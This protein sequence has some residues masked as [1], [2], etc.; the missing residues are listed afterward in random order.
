[1]CS[2]DLDCEGQA[3]FILHLFRS[4]QHLH[5]KYGS[6]RN[7][8]HVAFPDHLFDMSECDK[9][10]LWD[11]AMR[12]GSLASKQ[13]L[14]CDIVMLSAAGAALGDG[15]CGLGGHSTCVLV[16]ASNRDAPHDILM[17][18]TN[19]MVWDDDERVIS[20]GSTGTKMTLLQAANALTS[21]I[22]KLLGPVDQNDGRLKIGRAHV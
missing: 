4:F 5:E 7:S 22:Q 18:G 15:Q 2:S 10:D 12:I 16:N 14:R 3:T 9:L 6:D 1:M 21:Q 17:E 19:S 8:Y 11:L 13:D 20:V